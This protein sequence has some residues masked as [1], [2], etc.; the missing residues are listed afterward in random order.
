MKKFAIFAVTFILASIA[1]SFMTGCAGKSETV[2]DT[3]SADSV[4]VDSL[5]VDTIAAD[6]VAWEKDKFDKQQKRTSSRSYFFTFCLRYDDALLEEQG[7][8]L[9]AVWVSAWW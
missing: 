7:A 3:I 1:T 5:A 4:L 8:E 2:Q 6:S 9:A